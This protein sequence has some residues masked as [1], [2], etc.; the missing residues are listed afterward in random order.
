MTPLL[1]GGR[2]LLLFAMISRH[3]S[4]VKLWASLPPLAWYETPAGDSSLRIR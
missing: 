2:Q 1:A 3:L 4:I